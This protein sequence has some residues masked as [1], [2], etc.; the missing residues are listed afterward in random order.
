MTTTSFRG[1]ATAR[2]T[3]AGITVDLYG[4][5]SAAAEA[6]IDTIIPGLHQT[7][8]TGE[9]VVEV[10]RAAAVIAGQPN[11]LP[12]KTD[13]G[14]VAHL[15]SHLA[16]LSEAL[17]VIRADYISPERLAA[18]TIAASPRAQAAI[19]RLMYQFLSYPRVCTLAEAAAR[20][21]EYGDATVEPA[22]TAPQ[23]PETFVSPV[24]Y[25]S[26]LGII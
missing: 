18:E 23:A 6:I 16:R 26:R 5:S 24:E 1:T 14:A 12:L 7:N 2:I 11:T 25:A 13:A 20:H 21:A 15:D 22:Y 3:H 9:P 10:T 19:V 17:K 4:A 8:V